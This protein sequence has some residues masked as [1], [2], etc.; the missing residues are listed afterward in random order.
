VIRG[1]RG[2]RGSEQ[3]TS[4]TA[5]ASRRRGTC[6]WGVAWSSSARTHEVAGGS[7]DKPSPS[8]RTSGGDQDSPSRLVHAAPHVSALRRRMM[9]CIMAVSDTC[10]SLVV[11]PKVYA[12]RRVG[13]ARVGGKCPRRRPWPPGAGARASGVSVWSSS[14]CTYGVAGW[15]GRQAQSESAY[16]CG[17][18]RLSESVW[19]MP[20]HL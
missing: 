6:V 2:P 13:P 15:S 17:G 19:C 20:R 8:R 11:S 16:K 3:V 4:G 14:A 5:L 1:P 7:E 18:P 12:A 10:P 9:D